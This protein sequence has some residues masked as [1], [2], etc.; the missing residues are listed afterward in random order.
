[1]TREARLVVPGYP[2]HVYM[3][4][5][6]RRRL[7]STDADRLMWLQDLE[8]GLEATRCQMHQHTIMD[9]HIHMIVTPPDQDS[10]SRMVKR[11]CQRYAQQ[12]N[13]QR[14]ASGK[15]FEERF[16]SKVIESERQLMVTTLYNDA[17]A[18]RAGMVEKPL[19]HA[20]STGPLHAGK[21]G[22]RISPF[23]WVPSDWY[24]RLGKGRNRCATIYQILM[25]NY[26]PS[27]DDPP[28]IWEV[29]EDDPDTQPYHRR[30]ERPDRTSAR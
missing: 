2:H 25:E 12:R 10:L 24:L 22:G 1:M 29:E 28:A 3:R 4:G 7:F 9:N 21:P 30:V 6:N 26:A 11:A 27:E 13:E 19:D 23:M 16:H 8:R 14:D 17:N 18:F 20:W 5:N 15:L